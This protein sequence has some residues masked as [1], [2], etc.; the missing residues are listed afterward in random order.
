MRKPRQSEAL[1][2]LQSR[3]KGISTSIAEFQLSS[4]PEPVQRYLRYTQIVGRKLI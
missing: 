2:L 4:L 1:E 3:Q